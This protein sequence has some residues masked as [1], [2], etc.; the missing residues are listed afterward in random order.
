M[1]PRFSLESGVGRARSQDSVAGTGVL[2]ELVARVNAEV[3]AA[4]YLSMASVI[5]QIRGLGW[6]IHE[7]GPSGLDCSH[8]ISGSTGALASW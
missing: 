5:G 1:H 8:G 2:V 7:R 4:R 6:I 3:V